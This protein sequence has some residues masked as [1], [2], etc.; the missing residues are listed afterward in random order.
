MAKSTFMEFGGIDDGFYGYEDVDLGIR[1]K[2]AGL[3]DHDRDGNANAIYKALKITA[4]LCGI[5]RR[6]ARY[7]TKPR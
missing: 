3:I 5:T 1:I 2:R 4:A 6:A 7:P